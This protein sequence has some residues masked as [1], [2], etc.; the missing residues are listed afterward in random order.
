[1]KFS[2]CVHPLEGLL[3]FFNSLNHPLIDQKPAETLDQSPFIDDFL[4]S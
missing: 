4:T 3:V 1:M 2:D